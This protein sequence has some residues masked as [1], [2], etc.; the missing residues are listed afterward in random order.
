MSGLHVCMSLLASLPAPLHVPVRVSVSVSVS[1]FFPRM[2]LDP[3]IV[4]PNTVSLS[5]QP[6]W[7]SLFPLFDRPLWDM[8]SPQ[9]SRGLL[10]RIHRASSHSAGGLPRISQA[11][12]LSSG[13]S[14]CSNQYPVVGSRFD[15]GVL[16]RWE[17][18][19]F[20][21]SRDTVPGRSN[22]FFPLLVEQSLTLFHQKSFT[23]LAHVV[24][25]MSCHGMTAGPGVCFTDDCVNDRL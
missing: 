1:V 23:I 5:V 19:L 24:S 21:L 13:S 8:W 3:T 9:L 16:R 4:H 7:P 6:D 10:Y 20:F 25:M 22:T 12:G 17:F 2:I 18:I 11:Y 15:H 14:G